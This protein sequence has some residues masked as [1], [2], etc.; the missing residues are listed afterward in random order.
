VDL[1]ILLYDGF[2]E[3][4]AIGPYE[5]FRN[6]SRAGADLETAMVT[7]ESRDRVTA[8]HGLD[9]GVDGR[10]GEPDVLLVPGGG[11]GDRAEAGAWGEYD[12]GDVFEPIARLHEA[13][14]TVATVC[15]GGMLAAG[16][17]ILAGRPATTHH[18]AHDDLREHAEFV[19]AR[20]VDDGDVLTCG[21]V[22]SGLDLAVHLVGREFGE[23]V[24]ERVCREME[25]DPSEDVLS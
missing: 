5:V 15:T 6:A 22:T 16:A 25:F 24:A 10:L 14:T 3:L 11:W 20:V 4:D 19:E 9:V 1:E 7:L 23:R 12:R 13:G 17:G 18:V 2:D 8:G 21:G